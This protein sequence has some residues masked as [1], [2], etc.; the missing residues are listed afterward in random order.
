MK[1]LQTKYNEDGWKLIVTK[2]KAGRIIISQKSKD[3]Y[4]HG[5]EP[6][7][8]KMDGEDLKKLKKLLREIEK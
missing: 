2:S 7:K 8:L 4:H 5:G 1:K 3:N 6:F